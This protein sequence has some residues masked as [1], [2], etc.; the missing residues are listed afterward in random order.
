MISTCD[1]TAL[2]QWD[3]SVAL[4]VDS[5]PYNNTHTHVAIFTQIILVH[6]WDSLVNVKLL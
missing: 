6:A 3:D 5:Q 1:L 4:Y 2:L